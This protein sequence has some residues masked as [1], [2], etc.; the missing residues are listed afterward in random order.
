[1]D[2]VND[3][4]HVNRSVSAMPS[5]EQHRLSN[6]E[7]FAHDKVPP[8]FSIEGEAS[9]RFGLVRNGDT[10]TEPMGT[11]GYIRQGTHLIFGVAQTRQLKGVKDN[12]IGE[13]PAS[14]FFSRHIPIRR[15]STRVEQKGNASIETLRDGENLV[16]WKDMLRDNQQ[17]YGSIVLPFK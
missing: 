11:D 17:V 1:M 2:D 15:A 14:I 16:S 7:T 10:T 13:S 9:I 4:D 12:S 6:L 5:S 3:E 8:L